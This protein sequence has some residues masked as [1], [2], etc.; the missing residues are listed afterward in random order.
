MEG[1]DSSVHG[2]GISRGRKAMQVIWLLLGNT[3][4][5]TYQRKTVMVAISQCAKIL[6][7]FDP[8][9]P[10]IVKPDCGVQT[11]LTCEY[12]KDSSRSL[13]S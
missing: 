2:K 11:L 1:Q 13:N 10:G 7:H 3:V 9:Y 8:K 6:S 5:G 4:G 12:N